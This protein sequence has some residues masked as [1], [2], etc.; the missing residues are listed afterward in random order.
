MDSTFVQNV[1]SELI[2]YICKDYFTDPLTLS[3][4]HNF[5]TPCL[6]LLWDDAQHPTRCPVC[7]AVSPQIDFES[8]IFAVKQVHASKES[9]ACQLPNSAKRVCRIHLVVK[10]LF[11]PSD[12]SLLCLHCSNSQRHATHRHSPILQAAEQCRVSTATVKCGRLRVLSGNEQK[13]IFIFLLLCF[14]Q[15]EFQNTMCQ[16]T[17]LKTRDTTL[18][19]LDKHLCS[20]KV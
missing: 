1:P 6:C 14:K 10:D 18:K 7:R 9:V 11:C 12:K 8:I 13:L 19:K 20:P 3:C 4:G 2:C 16:G 15:I 5:C 17:V